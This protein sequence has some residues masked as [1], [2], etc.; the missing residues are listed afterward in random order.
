MH[1]YEHRSGTNVLQLIDYFLSFPYRSDG[2]DDREAYPTSV[3]FMS[4]TFT[5][6]SEAEDK[7]GD[8]SYWDGTCIAIA[9]VTSGKVT[10]AFTTAYN[11]FIEKR[12]EFTTFKRELNIG[13]GRKS[14]K[15]TCPNCGSSIS[16][17]YGSRFKEC[18]VCGSKKVISDS[19]WKILHTKEGLMIK[20]SD[21]LA[22]EAGK[23]GVTFVAAIGW[24]S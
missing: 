21:T 16:L 2:N 7:A 20:A 15:V 9:K 14:T 18:P 19:N 13:Y 12:K 8:R 3:R 11:N 5:S 22:R 24:H 10:K 4:E 17:R 6:K 1:N 23:C